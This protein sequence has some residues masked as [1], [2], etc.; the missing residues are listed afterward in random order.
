MFHQQ[1][2]MLLFDI[3]TVWNFFKY[4]EFFTFLNTFRLTRNFMKSECINLMRVVFHVKGVVVNDNNKK[5]YNS[6]LV[7]LDRTRSSRCLSKASTLC[8][9][10]EE[11]HDERNTSQKKQEER[12]LWAN[13]F[14]LRCV[15]KKWRHGQPV[16]E[17]ATP[18]RVRATFCLYLAATSRSVRPA[19]TKWR[20]LAWSPAGG[21]RGAG[22]ARERRGHSVF[23]NDFATRFDWRPFAEWIIIITTLDSNERGPAS[24]RHVATRAAPWRRHRAKRDSDLL[25]VWF[26]M[27][28]H[29]RFTSWHENHDQAS[30]LFTL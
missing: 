9:S 30:M 24:W 10:L 25:T 15:Y 27:F 11:T 6:R 20:P 18:R 4:F 14:R 13:G 12:Y 22:G 3:L 7:R 28:S 26:Q 29:I 19:G 17:G 1:F 2:E 21:P 23:G 16:D 8:G 5:K